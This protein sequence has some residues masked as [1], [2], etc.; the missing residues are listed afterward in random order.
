MVRAITVLATF[1][2]SRNSCIDLLVSNMYVCTYTYTHT[3]THVCTYT[4]THAYIHTHVCMYVY[5][6]VHNNIDI[7]FI[8]KTNEET[9]PTIVYR[10]LGRF[11]L[12]FLCL[13]GVSGRSHPQAQKRKKK[14][15]SERLSK[16]IV[17]ASCG[18]KNNNASLQ[19]NN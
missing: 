1:R 7:D 3:Y 18:T 14:P 19:S 4:Y 10:S 11:L 2:S 13:V 16:M 5:T 9:S 17:A 12:S 15:T 6:Y 8:Q